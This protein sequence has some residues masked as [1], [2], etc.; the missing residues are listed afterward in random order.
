MR[1]SELHLA[2]FGPFTERT[3]VFEQTSNLHIVYGPNEAGKSSALRALKAL[4]Y[5]IDER[6][7]D[8]F[9]H[10]NDKLRI[11]GCLRDA[12]GRSLTVTRRKGR[13]NTLLAVDGAALD[14]NALAPFLQ[15]VTHELFEMLFAIDHHALVQG[16]KE[17]LDQK[18]EV[19]QALFSAS[20][21]SQTLHAVLNRLNEDAGSLFSRQRSTKTINTALKALAD[22]SK[23]I[24]E[25]SLS[26]WK[27]DEHRRTLLRIGSELDHVQAE[28]KHAQSHVNRLKRIK[29][30]L[31]KLA[32]R[33]ELLS[34]VEALGEV[35][36]LAGDFA[37]RHRRT[38]N[39]Q[40]IAHA[41]LQR[42]ASQ[43]NRLQEQLTGLAVRQPLLAQRD[44]IEALH[45]KLG[46]YNNAIR[47]RPGLELQRN[48]LLIDAER[49]LQ[50]VRPGFAL[51]DIEQLRPV[52][53]RK[54]RISELGSRHPVLTSRVKQAEAHLHDA[55][56]RRH[57]AD[58]E[59]QALPV[60]DSPHGLRLAIAAA[61]KLGDV[62]QAI[63]SAGVEV[64]TLEHH[65]IID[66]ER[67]SLI[68]DELERV[69][70]LPVPSRESIGHFEE[71][72]AT[73]DKRL[74]R[75]QE[76]QEQ[77]LRALSEASLNLDVIRRTCDLPTETDLNQVRSAREQ[78]WRVLR[79]RL[80]A[81]EHVATGAQ[82]LDEDGALPDVFE[83]R[84][85][86]ADTVADRLRREAERV[87]EKTRLLAQIEHGEQ[88]DV[89][90]AQLLGQCN[91]ERTQLTV[92]WDGL[93]T[94]CRIQPRTPRE[95]RE[96]L[97]SFEKLRERV[98]RLDQSR[99]QLHDL[100]R[101]RAT[102]M[103]LVNQQ[104]G[105]LG[106]SCRVAESLDALLAESEIVASELEH[107][108]LQRE[109]LDKEVKTLEANLE[110]TRS[111]H[112]S[113]L[114]ELDTW[115]QQ[116]TEAVAQMGLS[117]DASPTEADYVFDRLRD[118]FAKK[119]DAD[120]L[121]VRI[122]AIDNYTASYREDVRKLVEAVAPELLGLPA[123]SAVSRLHK[124]L[125][126]N[127]MHQSKRQ[128]IEE[129]ILRVTQEMSEAEVTI[130]TT[131]ERLDALGAEAKCGNPAAINEAE[132]RSDRYLRLK[133]EIGRLEEAIVDAGDGATLAQLAA[134]AA[135]VDADALA[136]QIDLLTKT[137]NEELEPRYRTLAETKGGHAKE[138][139]LMNG[140]DQ[141]MAFS[142][143]SQS[144]LAAIRAHSERY[145]RLKLAAKILRDVI[146]RYRK[147]NQ[148]PLLKRASEYFA[149]LT[150]GSFHELTTDFNDDDTPILAGIR[151]NGARVHVEGMSAG[152]RDQLY[153][154]LRLASLEKYME[155]AKP[156]PFIVDDIL[157]D[158][159]DA[160]SEAA[161]NALAILGEKTQVIL[162][163]H[164][165]RVV[166]Q[167]HALGAARSVVV[168]NL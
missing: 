131:G 8:C 90:I 87:H 35:V 27:W 59:R 48:Q 29:G 28:L 110:L 91:T 164:H 117:G 132:Q 124:L 166:E 98:G 83:A 47:D 92:E 129:D 126:E 143:Q 154:A 162:F 17:M 68:H 54:P 51:T 5:G 31:P 159:D 52:L 24:K 15:G 112:Q 53:A 137:I 113:A 16:G 89:E 104:L 80:E 107:V 106:K 65:C 73:I 86:A 57:N 138:L 147:A 150:C 151:H 45:A 102:Q 70:R 141:A 156:M 160:R 32:R 95:M 60:V 63:R 1:I 72:Y 10:A 22:L 121:D 69:A 103:Q 46:G 26:S 134:E 4:L 18:G 142:D 84:V 30:M 23:Q 49:L 11:G 148:G 36:V 43:L 115:T 50:E 2:A 7:A 111:E 9:I 153:L 37:E 64:T 163:T 61:R 39:E 123:E 20:L 120:K 158:F 38:M 133:E 136:G 130:R 157:V 88:R 12:Q 114:R 168:H 74:G 13:K 76:T 127:S 119:S 94:A 79:R 109:R 81:G 55:N 116:W 21:G 99:Q 140:N 105:S 144:V 100:E 101:S 128:Q 139:E 33:R 42:S 75:L 3:L 152:T 19:G 97:G 58:A 14:D 167:A 161:L 44:V 66:L 93:W 40:Q 67:L 145:V 155:S 135:Q 34:Q 96:W 56:A 82:A 77:T 25:H 146:E 108:I 85:A 62:D 118:V 165:S 41:S 6:T 125:S 149:M 78:V 122:L 71:A